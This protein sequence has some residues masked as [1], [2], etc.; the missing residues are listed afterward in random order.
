MK[1]LHDNLQLL[2]LFVGYSRILNP[3]IY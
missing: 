1:K 2:T 3:C